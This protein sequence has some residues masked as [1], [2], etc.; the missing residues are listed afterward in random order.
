MRLR[1]V[2]S[3]S[4]LL[5]FDLAFDYFGDGEDGFRSAI[6]CYWEEE[7]GYGGVGEYVVGLASDDG[8]G[9]EF[10]ERW[11]DVRHG[12]VKPLPVDASRI[13]M[14]EPSVGMDAYADTAIVALN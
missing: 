8:G 10:S 11:Y 5:A 7:G 1:R 9:N 13:V 4:C 6:R 3:F 2:F 14:E 12:A